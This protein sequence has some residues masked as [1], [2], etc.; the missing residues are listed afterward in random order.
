M[1]CVSTWRLPMS[2]GNSMASGRI[3]GQP[4]ASASRE[5][6]GEGDARLAGDD[7]NQQRIDVVHLGAG[8]PVGHAAVR[9][10][11]LAV[12]QLEAVDAVGDQRADLLGPP[13]ASAPGEVDEGAP[14][15]DAVAHGAA[16]DETVGA[17]LR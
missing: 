8:A 16:F 6:E 2:S 3:T 14:R 11:H 13:V 10:Q 15:I 4:V 1:Y 9:W 5:G 7:R 12:V 17:V